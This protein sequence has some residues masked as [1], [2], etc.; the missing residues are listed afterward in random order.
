MKSRNN[1]K[2]NIAE[3]RLYEL[4]GVRL[5]RKA[6]LWFEYIKH[7]RDGGK[8]EN[9]HPCNM[10]TSTLRRF[11]GYLIYNAAF[12]IISLI[13]VVI[14]FAITRIFLTENILVDIV[15]D[16][17]VVLDIYCLMLQRYIYLKLQQCIAKRRQAFLRTKSNRIIDIVEQLRNRTPSDTN[18]EQ[19]LLSEMKSKILSGS[20]VVFTTDSED[21]LLNIGQTMNPTPKCRN[22]DRCKDILLVD[23]IGRLPNKKNVITIKQC[24]V[25]HLQKA[26]KFAQKDNVLFGVCVVTISAPMEKAYKKIFPNPTL[27]S[28]IETIDVLLEAYSLHQKEI[29]AR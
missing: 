3:I 21:T 22:G 6:I 2:N 26:L 23:L 8:N 24:C 14:Y 7:I 9:Y 20:D 12:H 13:L 10:A 28:V 1:K 18:K 15:M 25:S 27:D 16:V 4:L 19:R 29:L 17:V 11:S 5:F